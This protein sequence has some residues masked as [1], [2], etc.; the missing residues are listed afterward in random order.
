MKLGK[1]LIFAIK[2]AFLI[3]VVINISIAIN[4]FEE[5]GVNWEVY[6]VYFVGAYIPYF[7]VK[8]LYA[9]FKLI[10]NGKL[11]WPNNKFFKYIPFLFLL[12]FTALYIIF[13]LILGYDN[14]TDWSIFIKNQ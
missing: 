5:G 6:F 7:I 12:A 13:P 9:I 1:E 8:F 11:E 3:F 2:I 10:V 4:T 14:D